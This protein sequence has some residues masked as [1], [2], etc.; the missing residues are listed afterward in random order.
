MKLPCCPILPLAQP[1]GH[2]VP[3]WH[4]RPCGRDDCGVPAG[5]CLACG[6]VVAQHIRASAVLLAR[7]Q[8]TLDRLEGTRPGPL[9]PRPAGRM[10]CWLAVPLLLSLSACCGLDRD[11]LGA[12]RSAVRAWASCSQPA[13]VSTETW[14]RTYRAVQDALEELDR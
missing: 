4:T 14:A 8:P 11:L 6:H 5:R 3:C 1:C 9:R 13:G 12:T 2:A 10:L 7:A